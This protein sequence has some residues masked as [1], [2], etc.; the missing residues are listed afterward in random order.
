MAGCT[1]GGDCETKLIYACSGAAN[2]G[3]LAD[4]VMRELN[5]DKVGASTC[6]AAMGADLSGFI[7]SAQNA[8]KNIVLDGCKV[9]CGAKIFQKHGIPYEHYIMTE[10]GVEKGKTPIT[11][12][13]IADV[14]SKIAASVCGEAKA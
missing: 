14:A 7:Q 1:C 3:L 10:F 5:R 12:E 2:T 8:A 11:G 9:S 4:Q 13:L 6:L